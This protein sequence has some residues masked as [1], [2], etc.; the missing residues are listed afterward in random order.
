MESSLVV[1]ASGGTVNIIIQAGTDGWWVEIPE[2][3]SWITPAR[4]YGSGDFKLS[5]T[6]EVNLSGAERS[7]NIILHPTF[8]LDPVTILVSQSK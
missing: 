8:G 5:A 7:G 3:I 2:D 1:S 4:K 6:V